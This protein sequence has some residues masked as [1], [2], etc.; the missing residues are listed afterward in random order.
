MAAAMASGSW[1]SSIPDWSN[2][3]VLHRNT[4]PARAHF[5]TYANEDDALSF[6]REQS[7]FHSLNGTWKFHYDQSPFEAPLWEDAIPQ[8]WDDIWVPGMWQLPEVQGNHSWGSPHYTNVVYPIPVTPPN[9][10]YAFNPTG[11]YW[12]EFEVPPDW[13]GEQIR[14]RYEG[15]DSAFHVWVN[16]EE[17]GYS[18]GSRNP[19]E[20]DITE[21]LRSDGENTL[22]T[23]VYQWS[24]GT[25]IEDQDMWWLS[26][27]F[28]DVYLIPFKES[29]IVDYEVRSDLDDDFGKGTLKANVTIQGQDGDL[30]I[31]L[32]SPG[33]ETLDEWSGSSLEQYSKEVSGDD[34][35]LWSPETPNLY[36]MLITFNGRTIS[37]KTGFRR[38]ELSGS[39]FLVNGEAIML[40]GVNRH[41][42]H[43]LTGR[44]IA[45]EDMRR[46]LVAMKR[47]NINTIRT[48]H[49]PPHPDFF[50]VADELG[51][52]IMAEADLECHGLDTELVPNNPDWEEAFIDRVEQ[53]VERYKNHPSVI[54]W[55]LGNEC[56][57]GVNQK[58]QYDWVKKRDPTRI[59]HY[60]ADKETESADMFSDMYA[61][62][63]EMREHLEQH[64]EKPYILCEYAHAMGNGPGGME[65]YVALMR[66]WPQFQGGL[67]WEWANHGLLKRE[68]DV[69]YYA[70]GGDFGDE[71]NDA[72]FIMDG[73]SLS[74]H[75]PMP[76]VI[77]FAKIIQPV[78]VKLTE[79]STQMVVTN[80]YDFVDLSRL[81]PRWHVV[82]DGKDNTEPKDLDLPQIPAGENRTVNLPDTGDLSG[83]AW[84][85]VEFQL[86]ED[87]KWADSGF[88]VAWDQLYI[89]GVS[90]NSTMQDRSL[91]D[92]DLNA[93]QGSGGSL[94]VEHN[95]T[96]L[97]VKNGDSIFGFD[98]L[99]GNLT[100]NANGVD[101][102]Q[103]G[104]EL[105]FYRAYTQNDIHGSDS[106]DWDSARIGEMATY[107]QGVTWEE[108]DVEV[109]V[110]FDVRAAP[111]TTMWAVEAHVVYTLTAGEDA[112][113][114]HVKGDF[115]EQ[116]TPDS[117]PRIGLLAV[118]PR[119]FEE[120]SWF[121][122]GPGEGYPDTKQ[123][124][125]FGQYDSTV[126][127]LWEHYDFP[128]ENGNR[129][130]ARWARLGNGHVTID[131]RRTDEQN[132]PFSF[133]ARRVMPHDIDDAK[134]PH[135][136]EDLDMTILNLD[137]DN[138]GVGSAGPGVFE[139]YRCKARPFEFEF[140]L[141][142]V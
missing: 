59:V 121:G 96:Q 15:V 46:D 61:G 129:P 112:F 29:A 56:K 69:E 43:H 65:E 86:R 113:K 107:V 60:E 16:G 105:Y 130:D 83:E 55:S 3:D 70:Y 74:D 2:L 76:S 131:A 1:P 34:F 75:S 20:F 91:L 103:R 47:A 30:K 41:E 4:I 54:I 78:G 11:S 100:W 87:T 104:P 31:R 98:L 85:T 79:D 25:W 52:W 109:T 68:G 93:R 111:K 135:D 49:Y 53:M 116:G 62:L 114:V 90:S 18:Q 33:G 22:A 110:D 38:V 99:R 66:E 40:H 94:E 80:Y 8:D 37:Q 125:R 102:L 138:H 19:S 28:R 42:H 17:V 35:K 10:S 5:Y 71:P 48:S 118:L 24:D 115:P 97:T 108:S 88:V 117:V 124:L 120:V 95:R 73:L 51:F 45:Y 133:T 123:S 72:D 57:Y 58:A 89:P 32:L 6:D 63:D 132:A 26:G 67:I 119:S 84:L 12:R 134:H 23:R 137:W 27:I 139:P 50:D 39:N 77:E 14:L 127:D 106:D 126:G 92:V 140:K 21:Y 7:L 141:S 142:L 122:R 9:V 136:I 36:T 101:I 81:Q 13:D 128:Q 44:T 82:Q 64:S